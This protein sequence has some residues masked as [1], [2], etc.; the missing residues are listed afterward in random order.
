[1]S[2]DDITDF[3]LNLCPLALKSLKH[4]HSMFKSNVSG[5]LEWFRQFL[6]G[7][8]RET[9]YLHM[10]QIK[11]YIWCSYLRW[12]TTAVRYRWSKK[13]LSL[14]LWMWLDIRARLEVDC[15]STNICYDSEWLLMAFYVG[16]P[17][18]FAVKIL[19]FHIK[20]VIDLLLFHIIII[21]TNWHIYSIYCVKLR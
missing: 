1:M 19:K 4:E 18:F 5:V 7:R 8:L 12:N 11:L 21:I 17:V 14:S 9:L 6:M 10:L 13:H 20:A 3:H 2:Y 15:E 16:Y